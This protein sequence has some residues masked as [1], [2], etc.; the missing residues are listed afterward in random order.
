[1]LKHKIDQNS[2]NSFW[3]EYWI[4]YVH[5]NSFVLE[6]ILECFMNIFWKLFDWTFLRNALH[7]FGIFQFIWNILD[8]QLLNVLDQFQ[9]CT[10]FSTEQSKMIPNTHWMSRNILK[11]W[12]FYSEYFSKIIRNILNCFLNTYRTYLFVLLQFIG[13]RLNK[14][15]YYLGTPFYENIWM[16]GN[17]FLNISKTN[18]NVSE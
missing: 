11:V 10:T 14:K 12:I 7:C 15:N 3:K 1:M 2:S 6:T 13:F 18:L 17:T 16:F 9:K 4:I 5:S 8:K